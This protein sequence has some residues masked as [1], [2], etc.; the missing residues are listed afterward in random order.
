MKKRITKAVGSASA[1]V[2][3][4]VLVLAGPAAAVDY[5]GQPGCGS[6]CPGGTFIKELIGWIGQYSI[7]AAVGAALFGF[8]YWAWAKS[9][10]GGYGMAAGQRYILAGFGGIAG[11]AM[12]TKIA[13]TIW[14]AGAAGG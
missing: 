10:G 7:W 13:T 1:V 3:T 9:Q 12:T 8:G 5:G 2:A 4:V 11:I 14:N 6:G